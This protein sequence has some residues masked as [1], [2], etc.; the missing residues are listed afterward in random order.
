MI[1][2]AW[3]DCCEPGGRRYRSSNLLH[4][5]ILST[6][7]ET[8]VRAGDACLFA[9]DWRQRAR[10]DEL[11]FESGRMVLIVSRKQ[12]APP[13]RLSIAPD[14]PTLGHLL[15][16]AVERVVNRWIELGRLPGALEDFLFRRRPR[17]LRN[18]EGPIIPPGTDTLEGCI[19]AA[20]EM[21]GTTLCVPSAYRTPRLGEDVHRRQDDRRLIYQGG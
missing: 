4:T 9:H 12:G 1:R 5:S 7:Q 20:L 19:A 21:R 16:P 10:I 3:A 17:F 8:K 15:A 11:D 18:Q 2:T 14:E 6:H 13:N